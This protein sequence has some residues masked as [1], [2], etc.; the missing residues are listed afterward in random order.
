MIPGDVLEREWLL[1]V[2][3]AEREAVGRA[4]QYTPPDAWDAPTP[5]RGQPVAA[6][7]AHLAASELAAAALY[8]GEEPSELAEY[9]KSLEGG[10]V[11]P[12]GFIEW[13]VAR[14][15]GQDVVSTAVEWGRAADL[16]LARASRT[17]DEDWRERRIRWVGEEELRA[18]YFLQNRVCQWWVHGQDIREGS[19]QELR[20]EHAP[21]FV[22]N[23]FAVRLIP[24]ALA[25]EGHD[26]PGMSVLVDLDGVGEGRW[27]Q[28]LRPGETPPEGR[29]PDVVIEG[30]GEWFALLACRRTD[31][32]LV[33]YEGLIG[34]G[35]DVAA[36]E[37]ILR[38]LRAFP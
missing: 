37:T 22:V 38:T 1:G 27:T 10:P 16:L 5:W 33:L 23:D 31:A 26:L 24:Y 19:G 18:G 6:V 32:D 20:R 34:L 29:P 13:S 36:G 14:R 35:G 7:L 11:T 4:V 28:G 9:A 12:D 30:R 25:R 21:T 15:A 2:A 8:G 3:R 17:S